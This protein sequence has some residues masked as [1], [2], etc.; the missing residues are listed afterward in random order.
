MYENISLLNDAIDPSESSKDLRIKTGFY[1]K[2]V[3]KY[4]FCH[5]FVA[6]L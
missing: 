5:S 2:W 4:A 1:I 6:K 3:K